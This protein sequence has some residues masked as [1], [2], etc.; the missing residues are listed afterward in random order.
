MNT[1][2]LKTVL[3]CVGAGALALGGAAAVPGFSMPPWLIFVGL[4]LAGICKAVS[5]QLSQTTGQSD[6]AQGIA[7]AQVAA[8]QAIHDAAKAPVV[9]TVKVGLLALVIGGSLF[10]AQGCKTSVALQAGQANGAIVASADAAMQAWSGW[11]KTHPSTSPASIL[12]VSNAYN[13]YWNS[14]LVV[15]NLCVAYVSN[16]TTNISSLITVATQTV[17]ASQTNLAN[18]VNQLSK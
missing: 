16:P 6:E 13:V 3:D 2:T 9:A 17:A 18:I 12:A 11:V 1:R 5:G 8:A 7:P 10:L 14:E 4:A 15:S